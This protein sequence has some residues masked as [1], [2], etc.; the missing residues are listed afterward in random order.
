M[1][2]LNLMTILMM[3]ASA[4]AGWLFAKK[5]AMAAAA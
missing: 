5:S 4:I 3:I 1:P 2:R